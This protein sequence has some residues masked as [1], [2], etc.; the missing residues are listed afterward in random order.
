MHNN[1]YS[2]TEYIVYFILG[3]IVFSSIHYFSSIKNNK[4]CALIP[5]IPVVGIYSMLL[6]KYNN[7]TKQ[8]NVLCSKFLYNICHFVMYTLIF[9]LFMLILLNYSNNF[10]L[11]LIISLIIWLILVYFI[12]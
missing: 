7:K 5:T 6:I 1:N 2:K 10:P 12:Y 8:T 3:G 9:Y 11:S 4:M